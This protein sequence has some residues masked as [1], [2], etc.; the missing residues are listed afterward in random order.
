M[1]KKTMLILGDSHVYAVQ[2]ALAGF[3]PESREISALRIATEKNGKI[4]GDIPLDDAIEKVAGLNADGLAVLML[5]GNQ[6]NTM[7]LIQHP[8]PFDIMM[9]EIAGGAVQPGA[10]IIPLATM[11]SFFAGTLRSGHGKNLSRF[12]HAAKCPIVCVAPPAPKQDA[13]H[14][15]KGAET[16]F[17]DHGI[18]EIGVTPAPVRLKLWTLQQEALQSFC[19][20]TGIIF[21][22]N[23]PGT[24][25]GE[26][27]LRREY[28]AP[29][30]THANADFAVLL[31]EQ[32]ALLQDGKR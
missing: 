29:D 13:E 20:E 31:L 10:E 18:S 1:N 32:L 7:G 19:R 9:P 25:D 16:Y 24:R 17:R 21:M 26:G 12:A 8:R 27:Y 2:D 11:R 28:Y 3:V 30:A 4:I 5:R 14:I 15:M 23:P 22:E 6:F